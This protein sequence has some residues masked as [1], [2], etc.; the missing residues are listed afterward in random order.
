V[1]G[2]PDGGDDSRGVGEQAGHVV[3][4]GV[5]Q[6]VHGGQIT[7]VVDH[8]STRRPRP[9]GDRAAHTRSGA[10]QT[11]IY[12]ARQ[13]ILGTPALIAQGIEHRFPK[14]GVVGSNPTGGTFR[15]RGRRIRPP[16]RLL[17]VTQPAWL[18]SGPGSVS[19]PDGT[20]GSGSSSSSSWF[21]THSSRAG[22]SGRRSPAIAVRCGV[23][24]GSR[25][26]MSGSLRAGTRRSSAVAGWRAASGLCAYR[27][28]GRVDVRAHP[29]AEPGE[30]RPGRYQF[31]SGPGVRCGERHRA[32]HQAPGLLELRD[33]FVAE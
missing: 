1:A 29:G 10:S 9:Q 21:W 4:Q 25:F 11:P 17:S 24:A 22:Y 33:R 8:R 28:W 27:V 2:D 15:G 5:R 30:R 3:D 26:G 20:G 18:C 14:P 16:W 19:R 6:R 12:I 32:S 23:P 7:A 31:H 13:V